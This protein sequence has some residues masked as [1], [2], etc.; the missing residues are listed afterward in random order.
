MAKLYL[1]FIVLGILG[2]A[3]Y[4]AYAYY[5]STQATIATLRENNAKLEVALETAT[6]SLAVMEATVEKTNK[7]NKQLQTDLQAAE[8]YSDELR[9][10][11][12]RLNL[13]Q[14]ALRDSEILEGK[15]NGATANLWREIMGESG[16]SDGSSRPLPSWL[17]RPEE[18]RDGD[19][20]S[21][22]D[23]SDDNPD[24]STAKTNTVE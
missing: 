16:S 10:K 13:V 23:S 6:E 19:Q 4:G 3:G 24:S 11:F 22:E 1:M 20:S 17:Q 2:G 14:E 7:L 5:T 21:N 8:A 12:S 18:T 15:M 9:S